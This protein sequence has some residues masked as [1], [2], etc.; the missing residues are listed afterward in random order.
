M[1]KFLLLG[2]TLISGMFFAAAC[3]GGSSSSS[4]NIRMF[5]AV[6][7][8]LNVLVGGASFDSSLAFGNGTAYASVKSGSEQIE[9]RGTTGSTADIIN[10]T[11][12]LTASDS[13]TFVAMGSVAVN[14][15]MF[16]DQTTPAAS[17]DFQL[18]FINASSYFGPMDIYVIPT[19]QNCY[20]SYVYTV[21]A[22]VSGLNFGGGS[23]YK[24]YTKT[25]SYQICIMQHDTKIAQ[26][27]GGF[28][29]YNSEDVKTIVIYDTDGA[30][31]LQTKTLTDASSS[32][33][34]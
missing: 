12:S 17:N 33:S 32:S 24:T 27:G 31:P 8:T 13:Y 20:S 11:E 28:A 1:K 22:D 23:G 3:G 30:P 15:V 9:W 16:T 25:G 10:A 7:A 5:N 21:S 34:S 2:L 4:A 29:T 18:R 6:D 26:Y 19:G 14:G